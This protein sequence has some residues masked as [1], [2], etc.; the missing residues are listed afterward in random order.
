VV[1][2]EHETLDILMTHDVLN[3]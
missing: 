1:F 2:H 3:F